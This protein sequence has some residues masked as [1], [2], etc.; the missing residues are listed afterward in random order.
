MKLYEYC[1]HT[2][3]DGRRSGP[4]SSTKLVVINQAGL[5]EIN[6]IWQ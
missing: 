1:L 2:E 6:T 4:T 5:T 3:V